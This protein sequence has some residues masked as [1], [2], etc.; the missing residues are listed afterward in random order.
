MWTACTPW[1]TLPARS[2]SRRAMWAPSCTSWR[3]STERRP[4]SA[5]PRG[6]QPIALARRLGCVAAT[7]PGS[8]S[9]RALRAA[10]ASPF[11]FPPAVRPSVSHNRQPAIRCDLPHF[12]MAM[13][14]R[15][16][17]GGRRFL[18]FSAA[19]YWRPL[20]ETIWGDCSRDATTAA[21]L[22]GLWSR[23]GAAKQPESLLARFL[24]Q[25]LCLLQSKQSAALSRRELPPDPPII[26][27]CTPP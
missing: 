18:Y 22:G 23:S 5:R 14:A 11:P 9:A 2:S 21:R 27:L 3:V 1:T 24:F 16:L 13:R 8:A 6:R 25:P 15:L 17:L 7:P 20:A 12:P 10:V 26:S 19:R 4:R